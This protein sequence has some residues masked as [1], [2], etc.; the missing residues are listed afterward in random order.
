MKG[1][2]Q[3]RQDEDALTRS[4]RERC[5]HALE[6]DVYLFWWNRPSGKWIQAG[7]LVAGPL[8]AMS[9]DR[10]VCTACGHWLSLG[11]SRDDS[12]AVRAE[13]AAAERFASYLDHNYKPGYD[14][15]DYCPT[16]K[17]DEL[18]ALCESL[19]LAAAIASH[20]EE[21]RE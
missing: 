6:H 20:D 16:N 3:I 9:W 1:L 21:Q 4:K 12:D 7:T 15:F 8:D 10:V 2:E 13:I 19:F 11:P 17:S 14:R 18:C 5:K